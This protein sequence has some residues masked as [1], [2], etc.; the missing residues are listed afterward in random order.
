LDLKLHELKKG[1]QKMSA[2]SQS[3][4]REMREL[5]SKSLKEGESSSAAK[6]KGPIQMLGENPPGI[7]VDARTGGFAKLD[8][9]L[10]FG[11]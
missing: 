11:R 6:E 9:S 4:F 5:F 7:R 10:L 3:N 8:F 2:E 1:M